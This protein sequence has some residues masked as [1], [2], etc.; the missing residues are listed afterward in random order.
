MPSAPA[1][2]LPLPSPIDRRSRAASP[3]P[4]TRRRNLPLPRVR[5]HR[6]TAPA[7]RLRAGRR[8][9]GRRCGGNAEL[10]SSARR[11]LCAG[12]GA[13]P[14]VARAAGA[15]RACRK[16]S[17]KILSQSCACRRDHDVRPAGQPGASPDAPWRRAD[18]RSS[19]RRMNSGRRASAAS[20]RSEG[21]RPSTALTPAA[22]ACHYGNGCVFHFVRDFNLKGSALRSPT[23]PRRGRDGDRARRHRHMHRTGR[24][25][26][27]HSMPGQRSSSRR[28]R[29]RS[30]TWWRGRPSR[31]PTGP[32]AA[33][34]C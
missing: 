1:S 14:D 16:N 28:K 25:R 5:E 30:A 26:W 19:C 21:W 7:A 34:C 10:P 13:R 3:T 11:R 32:S 15:V 22:L 18:R 8:R 31:S 9:A 6:S 12:S 23:L 2:C 27:A 20:S 17:D 4:R 33:T 24:R 29:A